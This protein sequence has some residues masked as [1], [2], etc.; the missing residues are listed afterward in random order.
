LAVQ[1][2]ALDKRT[3]KKEAARPFGGRQF[4]GAIAQRANIE[5]R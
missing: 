3:H 1:P 4:D 2:L 5:T